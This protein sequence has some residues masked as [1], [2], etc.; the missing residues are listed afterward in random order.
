MRRYLNEL[1]AVVFLAAAASALVLPYLAGREIPLDLSLA[2]TLAPWQQP[3]ATVE[4]A[5]SERHVYE[6]YPAYLHMADIREHGGLLWN[7]SDGLGAPFLAQW[8]TR[9]LSPFSIPVYL[10]GL[11]LGLALSNLL[12][13][14]VAGLCTYYAG[15]RF[16]LRPATAAAVGGIYMASAPVFLWSAEPLGDAMPW[17]PLLLLGAERLALGK[18]K[19]W[20]LVGLV[21]F[22]IA[23]GG[24]P[25][26][27]AGALWF[28][29]A[30]V[31]L[32]AEEGPVGKRLAM[33]APAL[34]GIIL[35]LL[36]A[37]AQWWPF[38][39][40]LGQTTA[41]ETAMQPVA[42]LGWRGFFLPAAAGPHGQAAAL[43][44]PGL[45]P[46]L[47]LPLWWVLRSY[48]APDLHARTKALLGVAVLSTLLA[49]LAGTLPQPLF[50]PWLDASTFLLPAAIAFAFIAGAVAEEWILLRAP[51]VREALPPLMGLVPVSWIVYIA[52]IGFV[53]VTSGAPILSLAAPVLVT[54]AA[55]ILFAYT[56]FRPS[57]GT[58]GYGLVVIAA[59][60][61][62][63]ML[64][65]LKPSSS[66]TE[67]LPPAPF[68]AALTSGEFSRIA[69]SG[70]L[71]S[72]PLGLLGMQQCYAPNTAGLERLER[73][74]R[75]AA[76]MPQLLRRT[77][78]QGLLLTKQ[79]IHGEMSDIRPVLKTKAVFEQGAILFEDTSMAPRAHVIYAGKTIKGSEELPGSAG[80]LS[81][82]EGAILPEDG[83][84]ETGAAT[85]GIEKP[86]EVRISIPETP[87][88]VLV[89]A[90]QWYPG[91]R[92]T[93][94]GRE[95]AVA[96]VDAAFRGVEI[97]G[98]AHDVVLRYRP[99]PFTW[100]LAVSG[101]TLLILIAGLFK[102]AGRPELAEERI[103]EHT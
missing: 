24:H 68:A 69:G 31:P 86:E 67:P 28:L 46:I 56:L 62:L 80:E 100:G 57:A 47:S 37:A 77:G 19:A 65:P 92:A 94:D 27:L 23:L 18:R 48:M 51:Q 49:L 91:W 63:G 2:R 95:A 88:G 53:V 97:S 98:G 71:G 39:E 36:A 59:L 42:G 3:G 52:L 15:R 70:T 11:P 73:F 72:W 16:G 84:L 43:L 78:A 102:G 99:A 74:Q 87:P 45:L 41:G 44:F 8:H 14:V 50:A 66:A 32:R 5:L 64:R 6:T 40:Y 25:P 21:T 30:Y 26:A 103:S 93:V 83:A 34:A 81:L 20:P 38:L 9:A 75:A 85:V 76:E 12:K 35:G 1:I 101:I 22:L 61:S 29:V 89:L 79:D 58:L 82:I 17:V 33:A 90:D 4:T 96:P 7:P 55:F 60:A 10:V 54:L 13:L